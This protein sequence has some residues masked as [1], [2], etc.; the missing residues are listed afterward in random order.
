MTRLPFDST[1]PPPPEVDKQHP[2]SVSDLAAAIKS[3]L[4]TQL[5][6]KVVVLGE[7]S[8]FTERS[9]WFFSI[10]D[11]GAA[12]RCVCFASNARR[13][14][15]RPTDGMQVIVT[16]RVD[17]YDAQ[18]SVQLYV[19]AMQQAGLGELERRLREL[20][21]QL[22]QKGYFDESRKKPLPLVPR[23]IAIVTSR[24]AA[25]LQDV[26]NTAHRR[27]PGC[28]LLLYDVRVQGD[29]AAPQIA[30]AINAIS[31][32]GP[33]LDIDAIILTRG[34]GSIEDLWAFNERIVA[35]AVVKCRIPIGAA[36]GHE[37]D[38][39][40]AELCADARCST[41][42][43]AAMTLV[44][45]RAALMQ[46]VDQLGSRLKLMLKQNVSNS[47][48]R[49]T[50]AARFDLFRNPRKL[51]DE[52]RRRTGEIARRLDTAMPRRCKEAQAKLLSLTR[53]LEAL[54][55]RKVLQRGYSYTLGPDGHVL[56]KATAVKPGDA[57]T[58]HL[59]DGKIHS[60]VEGQPSHP[61][62][63]KSST[64]PAKNKDTP[65]LFT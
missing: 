35:D 47:R 6:R 39:T 37:T 17:F 40:I 31:K 32:G 50:A 65:T 45:D 9:H 48:H 15:L 28:R 52:A 19:D 55:P 42:T 26:I 56:R 29:D 46:Q 34:G 30:A 43:Q 51:F 25:A 21:E 62:P 54:G 44:P 53:H 58:T 22:R 63:R 3:A 7:I 11:E 24:T 18:G 27:W 5:P 64:S 13:L 61:R 38:T 59:S 16:G 23:K 57:L 14:N 49:L 60:V 10:K 8:N 36:I 33:K 2:W 1:Q 41:P 20:M 4:N 12:L